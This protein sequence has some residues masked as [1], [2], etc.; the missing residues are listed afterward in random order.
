MQNP[1]IEI[2]DD[3][4]PHVVTRPN[5]PHHTIHGNLHFFTYN[6]GFITSI[7][8]SNY[9][10]I[11]EN[12]LQTLV[13]IGKATIPQNY[14]TSTIHYEY[15][16][17]ILFLQRSPTLNLQG[18]HDERTLSTPYT[19][20]T[21]AIT[22]MSEIL[23]GGDEDYPEDAIYPSGV[24]ILIYSFKA[25]YV[26]GSNRGGLMK[27]VHDFIIISHITRLNCLYTTL[28]HGLLVCQKGVSSLVMNNQ[29]VTQLGSNL[30]RDIHRRFPNTNSYDPEEV[31]NGFTQ[32]LFYQNP[33]IHVRV[34]CF[35]LQFNVKFDIYFHSYEYTIYLRIQDHHAQLVWPREEVSTVVLSKLA[36]LYK[37][38]RPQEVYMIP[39][40]T[41][42]LL[43]DPTV[44]KYIYKDRQ[45]STEQE[46]EN[47]AFNNNILFFQDNFNTT[48][49]V[50]KPL[51]KTSPKWKKQKQGPKD[52]ACYDIESIA[53]LQTGRQIPM[54][55]GLCYTDFDDITGEEVM[56]TKIYWG[57]DCIEQFFKYLGDNIHLF[58]DKILYAH[59]QSYYDGFLIMQKVINQ[60]K[61][62]IDSPSLLI[63]DNG[64]LSFKLKYGSSKIHFKDSL[65]MLPFS[66]KTLGE[67][68]KV[69]H[70]KISLD[71]S[72]KMLKWEDNKA[73]LEKYLTHDILCLYE[74]LQCMN[75][76]L[77]K[78]LG[79]EF[80][81]MTT[82]PSSSINYFM[83]KLWKPNVHP[84]P[85]LVTPLE[86][87]IR[88][89]YFG[90]RTECNQLGQFKSIAGVQWLQYFDVNSLYPFVMDK[91]LFPCGIPQP[92]TLQ[93]MRDKKLIDDNDIITEKCY[94]FLWVDVQGDAL[95]H[96]IKTKE[97]LL[98]P[99]FDEWTSLTLWSE[100]IKFA[101]K[102]KLNMKYRIKGMIQ[103]NSGA[104][105]KEY[106]QFFY[107]QKKNAH[108]PVTKQIAKLRLN[109]FY[110][111]FGMVL[112]KDCIKFLDKFHNDTIEDLW[113]NNKLKDI[114]PVGEYFLVEHK[115][116]IK[117]K[118]PAVYIAN[119]V[120]AAARLEQYKIQLELRR[121]GC[122]ILYGDTDS[123][124]YLCYNL[125]TLRSSEFF[126]T[127][128]SRGDDLGCL[129]D[130]IKEGLKKDPNHDLVTGYQERLGIPDQHKNWIVPIEEL[131]IAGL[132]MY[133]IKCQL[134]PTQFFEKEALKGLK[135]KEHPTH[136]FQQLFT[137][138]GLEHKEIQFKSKHPSLLG[139]QETLQVYVTEI[140][141][142]FKSGYTKGRLQQLTN[143]NT[144]IHPWNISELDSNN[145]IHNKDNEWNF[146]LTS[147]MTTE[148]IRN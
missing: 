133:H 36:T 2:I 7:D 80:T 20:E 74:V 33:Q 58:E 24:I 89:S 41:E 103:F 98:F 27:G 62:K 8:P 53:D 59:N 3:L 19:S 22:R 88:S 85:I 51:K 110:G 70:Q 43:W 15:R 140:Q 130:E 72:N 11:I 97:R 93:Q 145:V 117:S 4:I 86:R 87:I 47:Y 5:S 82:I 118:C 128:L 14:F 65:K 68:F 83:D 96:G 115:D 1:T 143:G 42:H 135:K 48:K 112:E 111:Y 13:S 55:I 146:I 131:S 49:F 127:Y 6:T 28:A 108:D 109:S 104:I 100:E 63:V 44:E 91:Y 136:D 139:A 120:T 113:H 26:H 147:K 124:I 102:E 142:T 101:I 138:E 114:R 16:L 66:L 23:T 67:T 137:S 105:F 92:L 134:G 50:E 121:L 18:E 75:T 64:F 9:S 84:L 78:S 54:A 141:K 40:T 107:E 123:T 10:Q 57:L 37:S 144:L 32:H 71:I 132:K 45:F 106:I 94:G 39:G 56:I 12:Q 52:I 34:I 126:T 69:Q 125:D 73:E 29:K 25:P 17:R 61:W 46:F 31:I 99:I 77:K 95:L 119:A 79:E 38:M 129:K 148:P 122:T 76:G 30:K 116:V 21:E 90:G 35:D 60:T 81:E